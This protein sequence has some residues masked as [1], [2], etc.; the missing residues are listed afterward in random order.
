MERQYARMFFEVR[1]ISTFVN[2]WISPEEERESKQSQRSRKLR[3]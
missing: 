2:Q 3:I 1:K